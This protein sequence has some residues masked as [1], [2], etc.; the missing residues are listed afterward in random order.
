MTERSLKELVEKERKG[1]KRKEKSAK[2]KKAHS[3]RDISNTAAVCREQVQYRNGIPEVTTI[4]AVHYAFPFTA[5]LNKKR[6]TLFDN[7]SMSP[8]DLT[9]TCECGYSSPK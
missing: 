2:S 7:M 9:N 3:Y 1:L 4:V 8:S 5:V 6:V